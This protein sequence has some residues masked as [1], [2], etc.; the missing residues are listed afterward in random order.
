M[1]N[2]VGYYIIRSAAVRFVSSAGIVG[3]EGKIFFTKESPPYVRFFSENNLPRA[4]D[5]FLRRIFQVLQILFG[6]ESPL[7]E[8]ILAKTCRVHKFLSEENLTM[9][10]DSFWR[11]VSP[12]RR[13]LFQ[14][15]SLSFPKRI[16]PLRQ[17][18]FEQES[19]SHRMDNHRVVTIPWIPKTLNLQ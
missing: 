1:Y 11:R 16:S 10:P 4:T 17:I 5:S 7:R 9:V 12:L 6:K 13:T 3:C 19:E 8:A 14:K 18:L 2:M 15:E